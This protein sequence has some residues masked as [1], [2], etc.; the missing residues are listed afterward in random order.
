[1]KL[2]PFFLEKNGS[3]EF[4]RAKAVQLILDA[5]KDIDSLII[6]S[7]AKNKL[8]ALVDFLIERKN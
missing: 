7:Y 8:K 6:E 5:W 4:A 3:L 2:F 1:V